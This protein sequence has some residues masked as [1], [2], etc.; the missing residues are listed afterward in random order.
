[1]QKLNN[2]ILKILIKALLNQIT[3][4]QKEKLKSNLEMVIRLIK[5]DLKDINKKNQKF[6]MKINKY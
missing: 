3:I 2:N 1:M 5:N 6:I 4:I